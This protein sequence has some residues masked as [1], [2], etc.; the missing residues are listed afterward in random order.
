MVELLIDTSILTLD[1]CKV[2]MDMTL[3]VSKK[4]WIELEFMI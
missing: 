1:F 3:K 4:G 2:K